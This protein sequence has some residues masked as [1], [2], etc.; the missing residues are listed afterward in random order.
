MEK[1]GKDGVI[2][3]ADGNIMDNEL[4]VAEG[5]ELARGYT[6]P[7][8]VTDAKTWKCVVG[9]L[10]EAHGSIRRH[11]TYES[12]ANRRTRKRRRGWIH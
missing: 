6:S 11:F 5:M 1:V 7:Y 2:T 3:V 12:V 10:M 8:F 4:K 9:L